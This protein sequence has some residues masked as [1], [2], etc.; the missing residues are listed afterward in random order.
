MRLDILERDFVR[1]YDTMLR[2]HRWNVSRIQRVADE[3]YLLIDLERAG[4]TH[5]I[6]LLYSASTSNRVYRAVAQTCE[7]IFTRHQPS[8]SDLRSYAG[9]IE[10][11]VKSIEELR[12][13]LFE[14]NQ[15][16]ETDGMVTD[17]IRKPKVAK[18][19]YL[20]IQ[21]ESPLAD[22]WLRLEQLTSVSVIAR[23]ISE[24]EEGSSN[25]ENISNRSQGVAFSLR[26]AVDYF[27]TASTPNANVTQRVLSMYYGVLS[28][29]TAETL[30]DPRGAAG[31]SEVESVTKGGH[32]LY[33]FDPE[34][35]TR[36]ED[37]IVGPLR[38]GF[39]P[40]WQSILGNVES[41]SYPEAKPKKAAQLETKYSEQ[42]VRLAEIMARIPELGS[43]LSKGTD[44]T[45]LCVRVTLD[46]DA[47]QGGLARNMSEPDR[48]YCLLSD[49][50]GRLDIESVR[51]FLP[52]RVSQ[53]QYVEDEEPGVHLRALVDHSEHDI[54]W[55]ALPLYRTPFARGSML[56][57]PLF[58][59]REFRA[60][61]FVLLYALSILVRYRPSLWR[62]I[63]EGD[64]DH[65]RA[66][67]STFVAVCER[68]LPA[69]FLS[70]IVGLPVLVRQPGSFF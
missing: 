24:R 42:T 15:D 2:S 32:G 50:S 40:F 1:H 16:F 33:V 39:F 3:D 46:S 28:F 47:N 62:Q 6:G 69:E 13:L 7:A 48:K 23:V 34:L 63:Q 55:N 22:I 21:S 67:V 36:P 56:I 57:S 10:V 30:A 58:G 18:A 5:R 17:S 66:I 51:R 44:E 59:S 68:V 14:W 20:E 45:P 37:L 19:R 43:L 35:K 9:G 70:S 29:A 65:L 61:A 31:L 49:P 8:E 12:S 27:R 25:N 4:Q 53:L 64:M 11:P 60:I 38:S 26:N 52:A 41:T 54:W